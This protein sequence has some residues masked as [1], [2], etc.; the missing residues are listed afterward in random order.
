MTA[1]PFWVS[2]PSHLKYVFSFACQIKLSCDRAVTLV[3]HFKFCCSNTEPRKLH[4][5]PTYLV[6]FL[7]FNLGKTTSGWPLRGRGQAQPDSEAQLCKSS[8][9]V[10]SMERKRSAMEVTRSLACWKL[11]QQKQT[12]Q[13][14]HMA[15]SQ[16]PEDLRLR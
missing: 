4:T 10:S 2:L 16:I 6:P 14:A 1:C 12:Q 11:G 15:Q 3:H 7:G 8:H 9:S 13:K 5:V